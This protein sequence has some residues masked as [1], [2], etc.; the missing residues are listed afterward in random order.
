MRYRLLFRWSV[1][2]GCEL[3]PAAHCGPVGRLPGAACDTAR[4]PAVV[5][6]RGAAAGVAPKTAP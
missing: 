6:G 5:T 2:L 1:P 4:F 3:E